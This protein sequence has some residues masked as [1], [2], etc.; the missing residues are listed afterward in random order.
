MLRVISFFLPN[1]NSFSGH[2]SPFSSHFT[3]P[4]FQI[5]VFACLLLSLVGRRL[6]PYERSAKVSPS[7]EASAALGTWE[8]SCRPLA[9]ISICRVH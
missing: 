3:W 2:G 5:G 4:G 7:P 9:K 1:L 6:M 8:A